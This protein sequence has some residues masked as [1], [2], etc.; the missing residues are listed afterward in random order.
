MNAHFPMSAFQKVAAS[1]SEWIARSGKVLAH[2]QPYGFEMNA[3]FPMSAFHKVAAS[4]SEWI[5]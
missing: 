4:V 3:H 2:A 5:A 1:V